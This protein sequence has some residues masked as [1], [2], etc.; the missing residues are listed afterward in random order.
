VR[1]LIVDD[2]RD[3]ASDLAA[4][5]RREGWVVDL[6]HDGHTGL[7]LAQYGEYDVLLLDI[8]LPGRSGYDV[9][10]KVRAE[11][12][13]TAIVMLSAKDGEYDQS[14]AF[15]L[16]AD[17]YVTKP[18][19][20][21]VLAARLQAVLRRSGIPRSLQLVC[22]DLV[23]ETTTRRVRRGRHEISLTPREFALLQHLMREPERVYSKADLLDAVWDSD[24]PGADNVVEVYVGYL[25]KKIDVPFDVGSLETVR[26]AGY[27][28]VPVRAEPAG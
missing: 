25:R 24:Y 20:P 18:F 12:P 17:D 14:D 6:A 8:M 13:K 23:L 3:L 26:G 10:K 11:D 5:L 9:L 7:A 2:E 15:E 28:L 1:L 19:S 27:R 16:G 4:L 21:V 22:G